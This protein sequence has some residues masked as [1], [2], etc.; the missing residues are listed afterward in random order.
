MG[1]P[2][3][4]DDVGAMCWN[5][6]KTWQVGWYDN[7]KISISPQVGQLW[8]ETIVGI[9]DFDNNILN[10]PVVVKIETGTATDQFI[11]FNRATGVNRQNDEADNEVTIVETGRDGE[12]YSQSFLKATLQ[13]GETFIYANWA[14]TNQNLSITA[15]TIITNPENNDPGYAVV[16]ACLFKLMLFMFIMYV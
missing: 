12:G 11:A 14:G 8:T 15:V 2:L 9:A 4:S 5:A 10:H 13:Q 3:Y 16:T 6:A 7:S 1:N